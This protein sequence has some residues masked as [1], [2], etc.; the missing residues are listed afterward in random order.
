MRFVEKATI[1]PQHCAVFPSLGASHRRGYFDTGVDLPGFDNR[2]Y[3]SVEAVEQMAQKLGW[4]PP[5]QQR[6]YDEK[7]AEAEREI[8]ELR[9]ELSKADEKLNAVHVLKQAG[10]VSE[11]KRGPKQA[12]K[13]SA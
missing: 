11:R 5:G 3:V 6:A 2:V 4:Y 12:Q 10:F 8:A 7:L 9:E 1:R 13:V